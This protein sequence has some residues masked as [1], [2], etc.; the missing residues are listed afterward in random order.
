MTTSIRLFLSY[1]ILVARVSLYSQT[2]VIY[3]IH[4]F[5]KMIWF[6]FIGKLELAM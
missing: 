2:Q 5:S 4:V 3:N 1:V 6:Y